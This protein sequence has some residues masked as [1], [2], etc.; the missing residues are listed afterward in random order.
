MS[1]AKS[2]DSICVDTVVT[3]HHLER[4]LSPGAVSSR[5]EYVM[6][7][8][9]LPAVVKQLKETGADNSWA[10]FMFRTGLPSLDTTDDC[11]NLQYSIESGTVGLDWVL[12]GPRNCA[13]KNNLSAFIHRCNYT[14]EARTMNDV[15]YL[16]VE[17]G[18]VVELGL[19]IILDFY[20]V[21][22][23]YAIGLL[24]EGFSLPSSLCCG[25]GIH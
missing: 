20:D 18:D 1:S 15:A 8:S 17:D 4:R 9:H 23:D 16:R 24:L 21:S 10:V 14:A 6:R 25:D 12:L 13:D 2:S 19:R 3:V 22:P 11:L 5:C 7:P